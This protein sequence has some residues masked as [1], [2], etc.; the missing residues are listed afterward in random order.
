LLDAGLLPGRSGEGRK[1]EGRERK[2]RRVGRREGGRK[3]ER[4]YPSLL[5]VALGGFLLVGGNGGIFL[6]ELSVE[7]D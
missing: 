1:E 6:G 7:L 5:L 4:T 3:G 2:T